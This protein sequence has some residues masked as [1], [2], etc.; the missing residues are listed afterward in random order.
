MLRLPSLL[1]EQYWQTPLVIRR[2]NPLHGVAQCLP[3]RTTRASRNVLAR[4][5]GASSWAHSSSTGSY[6]CTR[7]LAYRCYSPAFLAYPSIQVYT[8][9]SYSTR[10]L[11]LSDTVV[12]RVQS[13]FGYQ[14]KDPSLL[15]EA[16]QYGG[17]GRQPINGRNVNRG[18]QRLALV[19]DSILQYVLAKAWYQSNASQGKYRR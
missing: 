8:A 7:R 19:G 5:R 15:W 13:I 14:F 12:T 10:I 4:D 18:N 2:P 11:V 17:Y 16:L 3:Q 1:Q 6:L 9:K